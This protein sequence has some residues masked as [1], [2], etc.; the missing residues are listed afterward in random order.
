MFLKTFQY[1]VSEIEE[2]KDHKKDLVMKILE[3]EEIDSDEKWKKHNRKLREEMEAKAF[4]EN[5]FR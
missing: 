3:I 1:S 2:E 4:K 5:W